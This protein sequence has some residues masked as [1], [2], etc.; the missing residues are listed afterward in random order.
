MD[1]CREPLPKGFIVR[2]AIDFDDTI[3]VGGINGNRKDYGDVTTPLEF[4]PYAKEGLLQ[5]KAWGH[6]L[7]L[8]SGRANL[9][10]RFDFT[11]NPLSKTEGPPVWVDNELNQ[12]RYVQMLKFVEEHLPN[13][14][15]Y[16]DDGRQGKVSA[17]LF[18]DD[19]N[20]PLRPINWLEILTYC[21][22]L[23]SKA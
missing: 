22:T 17:D 4:L 2:I 10:G 1:S 14:F 9:A 23:P 11:L 15:A 12:R 3:V 21:R 13:V 6:D 8:Y 5:L 19:R 18:I 7:I 16:I 20:Y